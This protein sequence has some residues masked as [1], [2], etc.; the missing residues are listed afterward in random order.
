M[1][2][3]F[4]SPPSQAKAT[5]CPLGEKL[6]ERSLPGYWVNSTA[7]SLHAFSA[8]GGKASRASHAAPATTEMAAAARSHF[9]Y[10]VLP[11]HVFPDLGR[12]ASG[13][14]REASH[15]SSASADST[16]RAAGRRAA[17][18][19]SIGAMSAASHSGISRL[20]ADKGCGSR[21]WMAWAVSH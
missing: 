20:A 9:P 7:F 8:Q 14:G 10:L 2:R 15:V 11:D 3:L 4:N 12:I 18:R 6:G 19:W 21:V 13:L 16:S 17:S 5:D 1:S